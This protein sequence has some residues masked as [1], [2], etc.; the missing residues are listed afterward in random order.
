MDTP[1]I[2]IADDERSIAQGLSAVLEEEGY[3][4]EVAADGQKALENLL[5]G[6][7]GVILADLK[8]PKLDGLALLQEMQ[9]REITSE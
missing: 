9:A 6:T 7:F 5:E 4:V 3:A 2:L 8:M 1:K